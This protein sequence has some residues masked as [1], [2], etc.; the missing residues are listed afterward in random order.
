MEPVYLPFEG[1]KLPMPTLWYEYL[2]QLYGPEWIWLFCRSPAG[3][4]AQPPAVSDLLFRRQASAWDFYPGQCRDSAAD[5]RRLSADTLAVLF[6]HFRQ[7]SGGRYSEGSEHDGQIYDRDL[8]RSAAARH[9]CGAA[10][11]DSARRNGHL[12]RMAGRLDSG[13]DSVDFLLSRGTMKDW[14]LL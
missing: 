11:Q 9:A 6:C 3:M 12:V 13:G 7:V 2:V 1:E 4:D 14:R 5:R 8:R 10:F